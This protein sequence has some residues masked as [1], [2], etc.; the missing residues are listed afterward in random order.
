M[1]CAVN[2]KTVS[3]FASSSGSTN[4]SSCK[5]RSHEVYFWID[6]HRIIPISYL[7]LNVFA[8]VPCF[9]WNAGVSARNPLE[10]SSLL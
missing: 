5:V 7:E 3:F 8:C 6:V 10:E 9:T 2:H 4:F 1:R